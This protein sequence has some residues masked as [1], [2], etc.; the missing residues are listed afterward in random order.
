MRPLNN[1]NSIHCKLSKSLI[2][3]MAT[4]LELEKLKLEIPQLN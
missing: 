1:F 4:L 2:N 3:Q